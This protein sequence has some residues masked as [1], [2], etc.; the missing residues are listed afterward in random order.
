MKLSHH[1][2]LRMS[3]RAN[4]PKHEQKA[5]FRSAL[6][7]GKSSSEI[8]DKPLKQ[9]LISQEYRAKVKLYKGYIFI[10]SKNSKK[11]YTVYELPKKYKNNFEKIG[12][13][14]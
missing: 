2:K 1:S 9:F 10:Y 13:K 6:T 14:T 11:L 7:Y 12:D 8:N 3:Q 5:F 4:I